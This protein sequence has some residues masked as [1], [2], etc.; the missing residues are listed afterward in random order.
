MSSDNGSSDPDATAFD[1][2]AFLDEYDDVAYRDERILRSYI[3]D[4]Y[5]PSEIAEVIGVSPTTIRDWLHEHEIE[6]RDDE[7]D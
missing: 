1:V 5:N 4:G 7:G 2:E 3:D 6:W